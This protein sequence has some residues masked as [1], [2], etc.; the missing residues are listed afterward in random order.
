MITTRRWAAAGAIAF[1]AAILSACGWIGDDKPLEGNSF[2][3]KNVR[4]FD[5]TAVVENTTVVVRD[6]KVAAMNPAAPTT[7]LAVLDGKG[8]TLLPGLV[9][10]H[11]HAF[12]DDSFTDAAR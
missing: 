12:S 2:A 1:A 11:V 10:A 6:G 5:G 4:V 9:D 3:V 7:G 8:K